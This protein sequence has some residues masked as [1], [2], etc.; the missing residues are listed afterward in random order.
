MHTSHI[1]ITYNSHLDNRATASSTINFSHLQHSS[2]AS[3]FIDEATGSDETGTGTQN[4]PYKTLAYALFKHDTPDV[5][6][7]TRKDGEAPYDKPTDSS[8]KKAKKNADGLR[9]KAAKAAEIA[10]RE[11]KERAEAHKRLEESKKIVL[12]EDESLPKAVK[13]SKIST[14]LLV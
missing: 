3:V 4:A 12:V 7:Q 6:L 13:V 5:Q 10:E 11:A 9:K 14:F 2:M 8:L 1:L